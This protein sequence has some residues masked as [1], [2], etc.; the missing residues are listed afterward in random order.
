[1]LY[2][3]G[4]LIK[5]GK[6]R[7]S[8]ANWSQISNTNW[9]IKQRQNYLL[10]RIDFPKKRIAMNPLLYYTSKFTILLINIR[11]LPRIC[12][13]FPHLGENSS[14]RPPSPWHTLPYNQKVHPD[15]K[16]T[17]L[18]VFRFIEIHHS[19]YTVSTSG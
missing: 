13:V 17:H 3:P 12:H 9:L 6:T 7:S 10:L 1:M 19:H 14:W 15:E 5:F 11:Y 18:F 8:I 4:F 2:A 16:F